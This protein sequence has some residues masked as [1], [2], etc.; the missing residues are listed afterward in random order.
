MNCWARLYSLCTASRHS[1]SRSGLGVPV[2]QYK[3]FIGLAKAKRSGR[4]MGR[5]EDRLNRERQGHLI[6]TTTTPQAGIQRE[7]N[8][9][10]CYTYFRG[11]SSRA[12][13]LHAWVT[14]SAFIVKVDV[15]TV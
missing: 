2:G 7:V 9:F 10:H 13:F 3:Q 5:Q 4:H 11:R 8:S 6:I 1:D 14:A 15:E 12:S